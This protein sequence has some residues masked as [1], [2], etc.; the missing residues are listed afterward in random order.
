MST[1]ERIDTSEWI[2]SSEIIGDT[3]GGVLGSDIPSTG[4]SGAGYAY[5]DL[6]LPADAGKEICGRITTWPVG[7]T[8]FAAREDTS[9]DATAPDGV[10][11]FQYQLYVDYVATGSPTT[12]TLTFGGNASVAGQT[13][14]ATASL[15]GGSATGQV[16]ATVAGQV[17]TLAASLIAGT[18]SGAGSATVAGQTL[19]ATASLT[20]GT[21]VGVGAATVAGQTVTVGAGLV[22][23]AAS[24]N[25]PG[26]EQVP[27]NITATVDLGVEG[28]VSRAMSI[29]LA[30]HHLQYNPG[31]VFRD[32]TG[33]SQIK[34]IFNAHS[35][36]AASSAEDFDLA[37]GIVNAMGDL[38][39]FTKVRV[40]IV[41]A[42]PANVNNLIVGG[43]SSNQFASWLGGASHTVTVRPGGL[44]ALVAPDVT[45]YAVAAGTGDILRITNAAGGSSVQYDIIL[46]GVV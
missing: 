4:L 46:L 39:T 16:G 14:A 32:G 15:I 9:F 38:L 7:L 42:H 11:T 19:T 34:K 21:A 41:R 35:T 17:L 20:P 36:L 33:E 30:F 45:G 37:G 25:N 44:I 12:V 2:S 26:D 23:G 29:G 27:Q 22:A 18:A 6:S 13:L 24:S 31:F 28:F 40:L 1:S 8:T 3:G 43:A 5:N 10:Y